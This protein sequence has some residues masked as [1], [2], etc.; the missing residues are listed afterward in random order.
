MNCERLIS[1]R[2]W[3]IQ[4]TARLQG[5][6][7]PR[8]GYSEVVSYELRKTATEESEV[9][10]ADPDTTQP[11]RI[12]GVIINC[13]VLATLVTAM[14]LTVRLL[15][16]SSQVASNKLTCYKSWCDQSS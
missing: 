7:L 14:T 5:P 2:Q 6:P 10:L 13:V 16:K 1:L 9:L 8:C 11:D 15:G 4:N 12:S 3:R